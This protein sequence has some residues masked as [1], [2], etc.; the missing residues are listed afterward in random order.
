MNKKDHHKIILLAIAALSTSKVLA[1]TQQPVVITATRTAQTADNTLSPVIVITRDEINNSSVTEITDLLRMHAGIDIGRNGGPGQQTS[2]FLRGTD[3]NHTLVMIDGVKINPGTI[4]TPAI[5]NIRLDMIQRIEIVKGPRSTLYGS[6][7]IGGVINI[8]TRRPASKEI[9]L[10]MGGGSFGTANFSLDSHGTLAKDLKGGISISKLN[11]EGYP[12][13]TTSTIKRGYTN[14]SLQT[15]LRKN[16]GQSSMEI[17]HWVSSGTTEYL[18]F[19]LN[20]IDQDYRNSVSSLSATFNPTTTWSSQLKLS[21]MKDLID[22]NQ[23]SDFAHTDRNVLDWQNNIQVGEVQLITA[24]ITLSREKTRASVFGTGFNEKTAV[25][26]FYIQDDITQ[27]KHHLLAGIRIT[28]HEA[29]G[30]HTTGNLEY[31]YKLNKAWSFTAGTATGFRAPDSTDR[32]GFGGTPN[33][34]PEESRNIEIGLRYKQGIHRLEVNAFRN[35]IDNLIVYN[36]TTSKVENLEQARITGIET[37]YKV[38]L[39]QWAIQAELIA[40]DPENVTQSKQLARRAKRTVALSANYNHSLYRYGIQ[41]LGTSER[42][43]SDFSSTINA[44]YAVVNLN[45]VYRLSKNLS[46]TGKIDNVLDKKYELA[47]NY[48][49]TERSY[50]AELRYSF[51]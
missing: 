44:G 49:S 24:G 3:S 23:G 6:D 9:S 11:T 4:G 30:N 36:T 27:G 28:D 45:G 41:I 12:T 14:T 20:P 33:L 39:N 1:Q 51:K 7:A 17:N 19:F 40:Q 2:I 31:G 47:A 26:A 35:D 37:I 48:N 25:N 32:F 42:P 34:D 22:Q 38:Q 5:Q 43:D 18:D 13:R 46:L 8:I 29:F 15:Y 16:I 50:H 21:R 10:I